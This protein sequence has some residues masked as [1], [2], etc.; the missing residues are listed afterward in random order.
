MGPCADDQDVAD[1]G[2][3]VVN[4]QVIAVR[5]WKVGGVAMIAGIGHSGYPV[6][7]LGFGAEDRRY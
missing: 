7:D 1:V 3:L 6:S 5:Q 2:P 4:A